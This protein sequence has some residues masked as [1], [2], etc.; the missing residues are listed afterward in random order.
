MN[1]SREIKDQNRKLD[2]LDADT[3]HA[4]T[5]ADLITQKTKELIKKSG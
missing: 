4:Q 1:I 2:N 3:D 5:Q